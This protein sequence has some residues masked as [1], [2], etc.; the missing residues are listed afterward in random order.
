MNIFDNPVL[1][2]LSDSDPFV[3]IQTYDPKHGQSQRFYLHKQSLIMQLGDDAEGNVTEADLLNFCTV[4]RAKDNI[5]FQMIWLHGNYNDDVH[6]YQQTFFLPVDK[7]ERALSGERVKHLSHYP[8]R[9]EKTEI[10]F[11]E[12]AQKAIIAMDK[13][14]RHAIRRFI[15]DNFDYG[16]KEKL[17]VQ[18]DS[19]IG[20]FYFFS[21]VSKHEGGIVP[22]ET[23]VIGRDSKP[24]R[25][26][27][28]GLHT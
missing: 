11:T 13:L 9:Q 3:T 2:K 25:K 19:W 14:N 12:P 28:Y 16:H 21:T 1:V 5:C 24:H 26:V 15:R 23:E 6:G 27:F 22:H 7:V 10:W 4:A 17:V 8:V 18:T 20:G